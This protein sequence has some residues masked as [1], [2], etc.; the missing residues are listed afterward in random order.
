MYYNHDMCARRQA[1]ASICVMIKASATCLQE[2]SLDGV[3]VAPSE[4]GHLK[5]PTLSALTKLVLSNIWPQTTVP[6]TDRIVWHTWLCTQLPALHTLECHW[7]AIQPF[8]RRTVADLR[9]LRSLTLH[10]VGDVRRCVQD[11]LRFASPQLA[12][13]KIHVWRPQD[14]G[15]QQLWPLVGTLEASVR[16]ALEQRP[17]LRTLGFRDEDEGEQ[18]GIGAFCIDRDAPTSAFVE[19]GPSDDGVRDTWLT[20]LP[21]VDHLRLACAPGGHF[22]MGW[23]AS[24]PHLAPTELCTEA[25]AYYCMSTGFLARV[26]TLH[27]IGDERD[28]SSSTTQ[29]V[30]HEL[31]RLPSIATVI[32]DHVQ[33]TDNNGAVPTLPKTLVRFDIHSWADN[34]GNWEIDQT[35]PDAFISRWRTAWPVVL[36]FPSRHW[37]ECFCSNFPI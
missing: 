1:W 31:A 17:A 5:W 2:L 14:G 37:P 10:Y 36:H 30:L 26:Q 7:S 35:P 4:I 33:I 32:A 19:I 25:L 34:D 9:A 6:R 23:S 21:P 15:Q 12:S 28:D 20:W 11:V 18:D 22:A 29:L 13:L 24:T 8:D 3:A 16:K 27:L